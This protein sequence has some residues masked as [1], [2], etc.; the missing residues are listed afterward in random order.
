LNEQDKNYKGT[1]Q[2]EEDDREKITQLSAE[3]SAA[4]GRTDISF[5]ILIFILFLPKSVARYTGRRNR[6]DDS[7]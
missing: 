5:Q 3:L 7:N 1:E 4:R 6:S 2:L